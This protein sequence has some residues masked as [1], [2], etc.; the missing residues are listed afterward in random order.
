MA[1]QPGESGESR[2]KFQSGENREKAGTKILHQE[3][4]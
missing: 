4:F 1:T 3:I 2:E